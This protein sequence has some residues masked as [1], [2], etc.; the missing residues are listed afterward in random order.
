LKKEQICD[1]PYYCVPGFRS[2]VAVNNGLI[3]DK[4]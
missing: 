3:I 1:R 4:S 2:V